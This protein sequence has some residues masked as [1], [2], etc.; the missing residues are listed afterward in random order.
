MGY[1]TDFAG[2]FTLDKPLTP[3]HR[4]YLEAFAQT[5]RMQRNPEL[6]AKMPDPLRDAVGLPVGEQGEYFVGSTNNVGQDRT[7]D[8]TNFNQPPAD[9]PELWCQWTPSED[10]SA[11][12]WDQGEKFY[13]YTDW[14]IYLIQHFLAPWGYVLNGTV[15]WEGE[16]RGD[17]G[18]IVI[19]D[20]A[21]TTKT[22]NVVY[23]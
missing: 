6:A 15:E 20:N 22:G 12:V 13:H 1:H 7:P 3:E 17:L 4:A 18:Q 10:G 11:I 23:G 8:I 5:R 16:S 9:Q 19:T 2:Q 21:V 14:I